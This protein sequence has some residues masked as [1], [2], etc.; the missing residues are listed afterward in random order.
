MST[1]TTTLVVTVLLPDRVGI[2]AETTGTVFRLEG[3]IGAIRQTLVD[4]FFSLVFLASFADADAKALRARVEE[5][6]V[7]A[8]GADASVGVRVVG[9]LPSPVIPDGERFIATTRGRDKPG[10]IFAISS[11]FVEHGVNIETWQVDTHSD[12]IV[13]IAQVLIP[14][15]IDAHAIQR[16]FVDQ[17]AIHGLTAT[18]AHENIFR[19]TNEIGPIGSLLPPGEMHKIK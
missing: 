16:D 2:L 15:D 5:S 7:Q 17:M 19:A 10:T 1:S 18:L 8:L 12:K 14:A 9:R 11:F 3:D 13:Y 6:L 4:G